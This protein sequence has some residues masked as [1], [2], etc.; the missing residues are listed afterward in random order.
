[1][2]IVKFKY[3]D[4]FHCI[5]PECPD[6]CC[7]YW[8]ITLSKREYLDYKKMKCSPELKKIIDNSFVRKKKDGSEINYAEIKL[9]E[10]G[11]CP[12][13]GDD[14]LCRMQKE[15]GEG[16][17]DY[18]C[19]TYPRLWN[20][21][22]GQALICSCNTTCPYVNEL[23]INHPEG[24]EIVEEEYDGKNK[25][26]NQGMTS[27][28]STPKDWEGYPY[29]WTIKNAQVDILQNRSFT[30]AERLL[31]LGFFCQ[32]AEDYIKNN[33][34]EKI[35]GL[36][37][38]LLDNEACKKI[39]D[40]LKPTQTE[41]SSALKAINIFAKMYDA[42]YENPYAS[43]EIKKN[44]NAAKEFIG[45]NIESK[46]ENK[47]SFDINNGEK[48]YKAVEIYRKI[49]NDRPYIMENILVNT[50]FSQAPNNG[51]WLNFF[52]IA[53]FYSLLKICVPAFLPE[54]YTDRD[55]ALALTY[56]SKMILNSHLADKGAAFDFMANDSFDLPHAAFLIS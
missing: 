54:N 48:Y 3:Y 28:S 50:V 24:L 49:E 31:I 11:N 2:E 8:S 18:V 15:M 23:L 10:K 19:S 33:Q 42:I 45:A 14:G 16:V 56:T 40:S 35:Q 22:G 43:I 27:G 37:N 38:M 30:I 46:E 55:L 29:Y 7:R 20:R 53:V 25:Y 47:V 52:T 4:E 21:V 32:K 41:Y 17:L 39:A 9:D 5:G 6:T 12:I 51:I 1:M 44:F 13:L 34:G 26:I 36:A